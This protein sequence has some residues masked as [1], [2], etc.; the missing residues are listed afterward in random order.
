MQ[1]RAYW[2]AF[3]L[4]PTIG[5]KRFSLLLNHFGTA[6]AAWH[7]SERE[8]RAAGMDSRATDNILSVRSKLNPDNELLK[9]ERAGARLLTREDNEYPLL[10]RRLDDA[11]IVLYIRGSIAPAD[12]RSLAVVGTRRATTYGKDVAY[13]FSKQLAAHGVTIVSGLAHGIDAAAHQAAIDTGGR[14]I[15]VF[16]CGIDRT[17]PSDHRKLADMITERGA[18]I[19]EFP[20]GAR[21]EARHFPRR[22]RLISGISL[23]VL[24]VEAPLKSGALITADHAAEQGREVFAVPGNIF[25]SGS[26]GAHALI[27]DGAKLVTRVEDILD[28][29]DIVHEG[30]QTRVSTEKLAPADEVETLLLESL[31]H[32]P[33]HIDEIARQTG[34]PVSNV[35]SILTILELKGLARMVGH[36]QYC[37]TA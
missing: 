17:Y 14:T 36:M 37:I 13:Q 33:L 19:S 16:G 3:S 30:V 35:T 4:V 2:L 6:S 31:S 27:Q 18:L 8:L 34:L 7:A 22:N 24:I 21:P 23:G 5:T 25:N 10:L 11:P 1:E 29:L 15:A 9:V 32:D 28:E 12:E 20:I 26:E